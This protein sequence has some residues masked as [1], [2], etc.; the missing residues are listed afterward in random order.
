MSLDPR[1]LVQKAEKTLSSI[2]GGFSFFSSGKE[3]KYQSAADLYVQAGN[4]FKLE[5]HNK[6]AGAAFEKAASIHRDKLNEPDDAANIMIDAFKVYRKDSPEDAVRCLEAAIRQYTSKGNFRRAASHKESQGEL[7]EEIGDRKRALDCYD[8][9]AQWYEGDNAVAL[10]NK[11]WLKV[12]DI[13]ALEGDYYRAIENY[14]KVADASLGNN[15]MRYSVKEYFLKAGICILR[16]RT[17]SAPAE[18]SRGTERRTQDSRG[19]ASISCW[20]T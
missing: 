2:G 13:A 14:E 19:S 10:A 18:I 9:A 11:L 1:A 7:L 4:A 6:E 16:Q 3:D 12:A 8:S 15:L 20:W 17:L 5:K